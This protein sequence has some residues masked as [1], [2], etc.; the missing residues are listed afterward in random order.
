[1]RVRW[2]VLAF[3]AGCSFPHGTATG[4]ASGSGS[5]DAPI[6]IDA[7]VDTMEVPP[8]VMPDMELPPAD[9]DSD[10]IPDADDNCPMVAN[11][12]Q[13]DHDGDLHGDVC[14]HC[15]HLA[16]TADPDGDSDGV[17]DAC[18][19]RPGT[20][21]DSIAL[22]EGF[23]DATSIATWTSSGG[24]TWT[25]AGGVLTQSTTTA[26]STT[27]M[28]IAPGTF[29]RPAIT[30]GATVIAFGNAS[31][32]TNTPHVSV[33]AGID[34]THSYWCSVVDEGPNE[35]L[36]ATTISGNSFAFPS[37]NW[38]GTFAASS[39][40]QPTVALIGTHNVCTVLQGTSTTATVQG[41][42]TSTNGGVAVATRTASA[43]FDYVFVVEIGN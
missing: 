34:P 20:P 2:L 17:G 35:K 29:M 14:D 9:T 42:T 1:M 22:F 25:V 11:T 24:G 16:S 12:D 39:V 41:D 5:D 30:T 10:T 3:V 15:P 21:G 27:S 8:D 13:R 32:G 40:I 36:Y 28:L 19:P 37:T 26:S 18:D 7:P 6:V 4:D 31:N 38:P 43:S 23:Y 33:A